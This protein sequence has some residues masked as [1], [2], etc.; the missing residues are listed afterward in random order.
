[1]W[2]DYTNDVLTKTS[3]KRGVTLLIKCNSVWIAHIT[4]CYVLLVLQ[5]SLIFRTHSLSLSLN[6]FQEI[7]LVTSCDPQY[8]LVLANNCGGFVGKNCSGFAL[9]AVAVL[10]LTGLLSGELG[11]GK[12]GNGEGQ[13]WQDISGIPWGWHCLLLSPLPLGQPA[14]NT[15]TFLWDTQHGTSSPSSE[16]PNRKHPHFPQGHWE[17]TPSPSSGTPSR[18]QPHLSQT[19]SSSSRGEHPHLASPVPVTRDPQAWQS[20]IFPLKRLRL[21]LGRICFL[22]KGIYDCG[23]GLS[24]PLIPVLSW[25][26]ELWQV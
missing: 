18:E 21:S 13:H 5:T 10:G 8:P 26:V 15:L 14:W 4:A 20:S 7:T 23:F 17:R 24:A 16:T 2:C 9:G 25:H 11:D 6:K 19:P 22:S 1:M 3:Q 12:G